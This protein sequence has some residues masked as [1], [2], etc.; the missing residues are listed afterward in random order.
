VI[1]FTRHSLLSLKDMFPALAD[2]ADDAVGKDPADTLRELDAYALRGASCI[3]ARDNET[4][5]GYVLYGLADKFIAP[6]RQIPIVMRLREEGIQGAHTACH[7]HLRKAY[8]KTG[9]Q[10]AMSRAMAQAMLDEGADHLLLY[11]Y[12]TD[13]LAAYSLKQPGGRALDG[14]VDRNGRQVGVRN[15]AAYLAATAP[16]A[17]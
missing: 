1:A 16:E 12:A 10:L 4:L 17:T 9:T 13:Q 7:V 5:I 8:W 15:L 14:L 3:L 2:I 11:G 6:A